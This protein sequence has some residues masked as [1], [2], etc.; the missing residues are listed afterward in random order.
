MEQESKAN[1]YPL[2]NEGE[3]EEIKYS[4]VAIKPKNNKLSALSRIKTIQENDWKQWVGPDVKHS[5]RPGTSGLIKARAR[6]DPNTCEVKD[7]AR[8]KNLLKVMN[9][10]DVLDEDVIV[11][12]IGKFTEIG[13]NKLF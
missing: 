1:S 10:M 12:N 6:K 8:F 9:K 13:E 3:G 11:Q 5:G 4:T 2:D 7:E